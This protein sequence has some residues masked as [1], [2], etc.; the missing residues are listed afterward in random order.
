M[1]FIQKTM[2]FS[3]IDDDKVFPFNQV[4]CNWLKEGEKTSGKSLKSSGSKS[5]KS[6][7]ASSSISS[8][9]S[10]REKAFQEKI[11]VAELQGEASFMKKKR[12]AEQQAELLRFEE[13]M[14]K[15]RVRVKIYEHENQGQEMVFKVGLSSSKKTFLYLLQ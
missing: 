5:S 15:A 8:K 7:S 4:I 9:L 1:T 12:D 10:V 13:E 14:A 3:D 2:Q 6:N 11:H